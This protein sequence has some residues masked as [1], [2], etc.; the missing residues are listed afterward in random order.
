MERGKS[1]RTPGKKRP[2]QKRQI[3]K[4]KTGIVFDPA[5]ALLRHGIKKFT[6]TGDACGGV[7]HLRIIKSEGN[8]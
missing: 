3:T 5:D 2:D 7:M 6:I 8:H 1:E 4:W